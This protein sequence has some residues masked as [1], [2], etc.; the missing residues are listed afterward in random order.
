ML[1][2]SPLRPQRANTTHGNTVAFMSLSGVTVVVPHASWSRRKPAEE[3]LKK[4]QFD[5]R[6]A[7]EGELFK[8]LFR[9]QECVPPDCQPT[10]ELCARTSP[11]VTS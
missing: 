11:D 5:P 2:A 3:R 8:A 6:G 10:A 1:I 7:E 4:A 9:V